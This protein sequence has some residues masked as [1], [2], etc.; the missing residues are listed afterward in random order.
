MVAIQN[1]LRSLCANCANADNLETTSRPVSVVDLPLG[2]TEDRVCGTID[3]ER[4]L[5]EGKKQFEPGLLARAN[6]G[7]LYIDEVNLLDDHLV[8]ILLDVAASGWNKVERESVSIEHPAS[9]VLIGSG[10]PEEGELRPQLLDRFGLHAEVKTE[11][12]LE[13][14]VAIVERREAYDRD[15]ESFNRAFENQQRQLRQKN[16]K[17]SGDAAR[18]QNRSRAVNEN[19]AVLR[20]VEGRWSSR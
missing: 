17:S 19:R 7:F 16:R 13:N 15:P 2:A 10:N 6:R 11:S 8:D 5:S 12:Y 1:D 18:C 14:R 9:F 20:R 3:I 4:A